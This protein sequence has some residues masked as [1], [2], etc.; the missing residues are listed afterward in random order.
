MKELRSSST[1]PKSEIIPV[2]AAKKLDNDDRPLR[3]SKPAKSSGSSSKSSA[4]S[5]N[6]PPIEINSPNPSGSA[7]GGL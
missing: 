3:R 6:R 1:N 2:S 4:S 5:S 7:R